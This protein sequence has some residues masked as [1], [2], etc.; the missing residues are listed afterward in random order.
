MIRVHLTV[1]TQSELQALRRDPL[2]PRVRDRLEMVLLSDAGWSP[3]RIARH[4]GCDPQTARAVIHGFNARGVPALY[5]G[6]PGPAP[7]YA[8]RDQVAARLTDRLGQDRTWTA[9]QLADALRPNGIRLR[10]R[11]VRRYLARLRAGYRRTA[12]TLEHKQNRP[13]VARAA[14]VLGGLQRKAREGRLVL[15]YLDQCGFAPSLPG[16][17][18][19]CLP[20]Q[21]KRVRYEY[22]QGRRVNV[23]ATYEPLG[24]AP[25]LDAVPFERTLTSDDLVAYL[26]GRPAVGRPRVVVLDNAPIHTSKVVKAARPELAKSGVYLYYLPAYSPELN[27]IEAVFKQVKHHEIPTRSYATR[28]DLRAAVE[29]GFN[30]Y[31]QKLRPE[32][33]KQLR[34]AA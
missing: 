19:W 1:A 24:P 28:S 8:R 2:P 20:G 18:S 4:L 12:S 21:R 32:P 29:Q 5:P 23:L 33:G 30:S 10:A 25:R 27:R 11:Q 16:G 15:D 22:P 6:K 14:A 17:Y 3:P 13:K 34:P 7:N 9:A 31:A 26:R